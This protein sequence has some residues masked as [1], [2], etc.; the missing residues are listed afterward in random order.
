[1]NVYS[2]AL[3]MNEN[4]FFISTAN[5]KIFIS[6]ANDSFRTFISAA[7]QFYSLA[8]LMNGNIFFH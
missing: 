8:V 7:N 6:S 5:E 3:L 2:L 4:I 1:M